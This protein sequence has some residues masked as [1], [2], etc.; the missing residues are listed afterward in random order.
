MATCKSIRK[1]S[2]LNIFLIAAFRKELADRT[3]PRE[4]AVTAF[5]DEVNEGARIEACA[6]SGRMLA[7]KPLI[8]RLERNDATA[9]GIDPGSINYTRLADLDTA[10]DKARRD[11]PSIAV[12]DI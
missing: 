4:G 5:G 7:S 8:E 12:C 6:T 9:L 3:R 2:P 10:T 1:N 11:A